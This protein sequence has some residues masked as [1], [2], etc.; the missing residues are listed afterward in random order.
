M[1]C[2]S[3]FIGMRSDTKA[4]SKAM[5]IRDD[6]QE[7]ITASE[8]TQSTQLF[9][10]LPTQPTTQLTL[11]RD[12]FEYAEAINTE[13]LT[14]TSSSCA[15]RAHAGNREGRNEMIFDSALLLAS[16]SN[17]DSQ[18]QVPAYTSSACKTL[19]AR[20]RTRTVQSIQ[21]VFHV[22]SALPNRETIKANKMM[23]T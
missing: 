8:P 23:V 6:G 20:I 14:C 5:N 7:C 16:Q 2:A 10:K 21:F 11:S 19:T 18:R 9:E 12:T 1:D 15:A 3:E 13:T 17:V 4:Q 22:I